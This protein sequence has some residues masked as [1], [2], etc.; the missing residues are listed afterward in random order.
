MISADRPPLGLG[1]AYRF[2]GN[3]D[4]P[5]HVWV[6]CSLPDAQGTVAMINIT[7][8]RF[9]RD[10]TCLGADENC[11]IHAGEHGSVTH[12]SVM[13]Y[14]KAREFA[15]SQQAGVIAS[16]ERVRE[17]VLPGLLDRIQ[18]GALTS[19]DTPNKIKAR[20]RES[21]KRQADDELPKVGT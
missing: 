13:A 9:G 18:R 17:D 1:T 5:G 7:S 6:T 8:K 14:A 12:E 20:I 2:P 11:V 3:E 21:M 15:T 19:S 16:C 10:G 4:L